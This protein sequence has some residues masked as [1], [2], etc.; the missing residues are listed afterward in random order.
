MTNSRT[1]WIA[2]SSSTRKKAAQLEK[3]RAQEE[4]A[5]ALVA[6][7]R[8]LNQRKPGIVVAEDVTQTE[9]QLKAAAAESKIAKVEVAEV[10]LRIRQFERK[11]DRIKD[12][13]KLAE[14]KTKRAAVGTEH[15]VESG[16]RRPAHEISADEV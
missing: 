12:V 5:A 3:A 4:V 7:N 10:E 8:R 14:R 15:G 6:R 1:N 9:G 2:S 13:T 16:R 11:R